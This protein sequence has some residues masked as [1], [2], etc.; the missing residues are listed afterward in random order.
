MKEKFDYADLKDIAET[1]ACDNE[2]FALREEVIK[3]I[4][5]LPEINVKWSKLDRKILRYFAECPE[6]IPRDP[7]MF[8]RMLKADFGIEI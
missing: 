4:C 5:E 2:S 8:K 1:F 3:E 7:W 6:N